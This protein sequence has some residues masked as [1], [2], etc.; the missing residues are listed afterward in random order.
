MGN[1]CVFCVIAKGFLALK[2]VLSIELVLRNVDP[3]LAMT[4]E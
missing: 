3:N 2:R 4:T 1:V